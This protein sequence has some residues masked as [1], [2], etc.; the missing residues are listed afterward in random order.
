MEH[1]AALTLAK[2]TEFSPHQVVTNSPTEGETGPK[3]CPLHAHFYLHTATGVTMHYRSND[4]SSIHTSSILW[5]FFPLIKIYRFFRLSNKTVMI[6]LKMIYHNKQNGSHFIG[7]VLR[8]FL[9]TFWLWKKLNDY[10]NFQ[11]STSW[12]DVWNVPLFNTFGMF[13]LAL[14]LQLAICC[15]QL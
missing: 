4:D 6:I 11:T 9:C 13:W 1:P 8:L 10:N 7:R 14:N 15:I 5:V 2:V 3:A 12:F